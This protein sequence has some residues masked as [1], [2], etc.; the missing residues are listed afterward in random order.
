MIAVLLSHGPR[1]LLV[2]QSW[3]Q[4]SRPVAQKDEIHPRHLSHSL[5]SS[6]GGGLGG[7]TASPARASDPPKSGQ[8]PSEVFRAPPIT[9][10]EGQS[11]T[12]C[13][14]PEKACESLARTDSLPSFT[15][16]FTQQTLKADPVQRHR[17]DRCPGHSAGTG[18][19][20]KGGP[21]CIYDRPCKGPGVL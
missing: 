20:G 7:H 5:C 6:G 12:H 17:G 4:M 8:Q 18:G 2:L 15:Q 11:R 16:L 1:W 9:L 19:Y 21:S 3:C 13:P 10:A 14:P